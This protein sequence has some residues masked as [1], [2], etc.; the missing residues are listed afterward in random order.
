M[1]RAAPI[2]KPMLRMPSEQ[3]MLKDI[4]LKMPIID[5]LSENLDKLCERV[6]GMEVK[7]K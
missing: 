2:P 5:K 6:D 4:W 3:E 7:L 1:D